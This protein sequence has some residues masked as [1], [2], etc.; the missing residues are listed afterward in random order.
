MFKR[1]LSALT[2]VPSALISSAQLCSIMALFFLS[3]VASATPVRVSLDEDEAGLTFRIKSSSR[4]DSISSPLSKSMIKLSLSD[5]KEPLHRIE[6][7]DA[8]AKK[9]WLKDFTESKNHPFIKGILVRERQGGVQ[10]RTRFK[11]SPRLPRGYA[12]R[13]VISEA[14]GELFVKLP[15]P[16]KKSERPKPAVA[17][18]SAE[19]SS[20]QLKAEV[21]KIRHM[22]AQLKEGSE[23]KVKAKPSKA[24]GSPFERGVRPPPTPA[25]DVSPARPSMTVAQPTKSGAVV[26]ASPA[27]PTPI[28]TALS[29]SSPTSAIKSQDLRSSAQPTGSDAE[30]GSLAAPPLAKIPAPPP[31]EGTIE[32]LPNKAPKNELSELLSGESDGPT[33][34]QILIVALLFMV[35]LLGLFLMR[36][37]GKSPFGATSEIPFKVRSRQVVNAQWNQ[38]LLIVEVLD[39]TLLLG[40]S[41]SGGLSLLAQI[42]PDPYPQ[43][44]APPPYQGY[45]SYAES[46]DYGP[47]GYE[48]GRR[49]DA[50]SYQDEQ[51][52]H[53]GAYAED[54]YYADEHASPRLDDSARAPHHEPS[55]DDADSGYTLEVPMS[56]MDGIPAQSTADLTA[57]RAVPSGAYQ[58]SGLGGLEALVSEAQR[59][60]SAAQS[61]PEPSSV[62]ADDLLQKIRQLNQG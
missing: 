45:P 3:S 39:R 43:P 17:N 13:V 56:Q 46:D 52:F 24:E 19:E 44:A 5:D 49:Y 10:I 38:E 30:L 28:S 27:T 41:A 25:L 48:D 59:N 8:S 53:D 6:L 11:A 7:R 42:S 14:D 18:P 1:H 33:D 62:S 36:R 37:S 22:T 12:S 21:Q 61:T 15:S 16:L 55:L 20:T 60:S 26:P 40:S 4:G 51:S 50:P 32:P 58:S 47:E 23:P 54:E 35:A 34:R 29:P 31:S 57:E 9:K 2:T